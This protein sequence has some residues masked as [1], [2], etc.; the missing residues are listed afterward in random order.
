[1]ETQLNFI[2]LGNLTFIFNEMQGLN[3]TAE[4]N[5]QKE[6]N[7][8]TENFF[9]SIPAPKNRAEIHAQQIIKKQM[10]NK[11]ETRNRL[12]SK[13]HS[14]QLQNLNGTIEKIVTTQNLEISAKEKENRAY[15][16]SKQLLQ[17]EEL[18]HSRKIAKQSHQKNKKYQN[19]SVKNSIPI[20]N[21]K[22]EFNKISPSK[23][24][25]EELPQDEKISKFA[26][27][28]CS[29]PWKFSEH[30]RIKRWQIS[31]PQII[32]GFVDKDSDGQHIKYYQNLDDEQVLE[33]RARHFLP[34]TELLMNYPYRSIYTYPVDRGVAMHAQ[35]IFKQATYKGVLKLGVDKCNIIFHKYFEDE[36]IN[37]FNQNLFGLEKTTDVEDREAL[38]EWST[39]D[40]Y[41]LDISKAGVLQFHY[42]DHDIHIFPIDQDL[43]EQEL[44]KL[45]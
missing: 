39:K 18:I 37:A 32:R 22:K 24:N 8:I 10:K 36:N 21:E 19:N 34:G 1:M 4:K 42:S 35:L 17:E 31:D 2:S 28:L 43:L 3:T 11:I 13:H 26:L 6:L 41:I 45:V 44:N 14:R 5:L 23:K 12:V 33:Q 30:S 15:E 16:Y 38:N 9:N 27:N 7:S 20:I 40:N 29:S 25:G